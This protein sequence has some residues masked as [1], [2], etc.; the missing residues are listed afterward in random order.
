MGDVHAAGGVR[1]GRVFDA[2]AEDVPGAGR[3][4][5]KCNQLVF[6]SL[7]LVMLG[8]AIKGLTHSLNV[9]AHMSIETFAG[10][11]PRAQNGA[12]LCSF[13]SQ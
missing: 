2:P 7:G 3:D 1:V 6:K 13:E 9:G 8:L 12:R 4:S 11:T 5:K 10:R